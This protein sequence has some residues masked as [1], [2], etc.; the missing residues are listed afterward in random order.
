MAEV[1]KTRTTALTAVEFVIMLNDEAHK[2][3]NSAHSDGERQY[4]SDKIIEQIKG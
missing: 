4:T 1:L 3:Y 2:L